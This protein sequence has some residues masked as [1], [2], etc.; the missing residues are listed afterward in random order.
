MSVYW[1][2]PDIARYHCTS[3]HSRYR[4]C[5]WATNTVRVV[6]SSPRYRTRITARRLDVPQTTVWETM[7]HAKGACSTWNISDFVILLGGWNFGTGSMANAGC[8]VTACLLTKCKPITSVPLI[9]FSHV[10]RRRPSR[11]SEQLSI[12][13]QCQCVF[14]SSGWSAVWSF[15]LRTSSYR[16]DVPVISAGRIAP[17]SFYFIFWGGRAFE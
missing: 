17:I 4:W 9:R 1:S 3:R 15:H 10:V 13:L 7:H 8:I 5:R 11:Y 12:S 16:T 2:S 14:W 6:Q